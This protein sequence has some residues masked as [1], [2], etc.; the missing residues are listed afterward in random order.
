MV[1]AVDRALLILHA[2]VGG[3]CVGGLTSDLVRSARRL[4]AG[5]DAGARP[6]R[7]PWIAAALF[8]AAFV[9]GCVLYPPYRLEVRAGWLDAHRPE[10]A[11]LFDIKE[12]AAALALATLAAQV[13]LARRAHAAVVKDALTGVV[14][15]ALAAWNAAC[16]WLAVIVGLYTVSHRTFG[17]G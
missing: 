12:H 10:V 11:R 5:D 8:A 6:V 14:Y 2:L 7:P 9:L 4:R 17:A 3:A 13:Y 1:A 15:V 16:A